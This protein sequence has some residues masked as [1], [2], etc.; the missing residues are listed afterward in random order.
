MAPSSPISSKNTHT[1]LGHLQTAFFLATAPVNAPLSIT[2]EFTLQQA[3]GNG[4]TVDGDK[5]AGWRAGCCDESPALRVP[6]L[7]RSPH[8]PARLR[9]TV[10]LATET[11]QTSFMGLLSPTMLCCRLISARQPQILPFQPQQPPRIFKGRRRRDAGDAGN[12]FQMI[13]IKRVT[14]FVVSR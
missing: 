7:F 5:S 2:E 9:S 4:G 10:P 12:E 1:A 11:G 14:G 13:A 6:F 8:R 3:F